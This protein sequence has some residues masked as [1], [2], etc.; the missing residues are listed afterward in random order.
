LLQ[1]DYVMTK[2][3]VLAL[4]A[5][6]AGAPAAVDAS[7]IQFFPK[8]CGQRGFSPG[9]RSFGS[10]D[11]VGLTA[12]Q[13]LVCF[14]EHL[15]SVARTI[16][17]IS[18]LN[19]DTALVGIDF[20]VQD[21]KLYGVGNQGGVYT[22]NLETA[23]ATFVV[24]LDKSLEGTSFGVDFNP[25]ANRLRIIS[26]TGQ[27]LRADITNG[28]TVEDPDLNYPLPAVPPA[29]GITGAAYTNNDLNPDTGTTLF[30]ID[31]DLDQVDIQSPANAGIVVTTGKLLVDAAPQV[32]LDI[33]SKVREGR[34]VD[35][36]AV[37]VLVS[38]GR[39][40][41]YTVNLL[42]GRALQ[43][44]TFNQKDPVVDIAFPLNQF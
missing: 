28:V 17:A 30:D 15:P 6:L 7:S 42:T 27:N 26:D 9:V 40:R 3:H 10:L 2:G 16:G 18:G 44:G 22:L 43:R 33:Y 41:L 37:A 34:T 4:A 11:L 24:Q 1:E 31:S 20:R 21:G 36:Q 8:R 19:G 13:R 29:T 23:A 12:D 39:A 32:G 5:L 38:G 14:T 35:N 25:A